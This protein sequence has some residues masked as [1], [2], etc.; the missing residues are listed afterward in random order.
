M[1]K[2]T[3]ALVPRELC[4]ELLTPGVSPAQSPEAAGSCTKPERPPGGSS[5][6]AVCAWDRKHWRPP[7]GLARGRWMTLTVSELGPRKLVIWEHGLRV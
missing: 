4:L 2:V 1:L 7:G 5:E 3:C 6:L